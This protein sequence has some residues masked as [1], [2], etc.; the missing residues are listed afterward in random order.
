MH[1]AGFSSDTYDRYVLGLLE[2]PDRS[3][4]ESQIQEQC[5]A[6]LNGVQRSMN[7]WLVFAETLENAEPSEDFRG[8]VVRIAELSK[9]V[10]TFP[11]NSPALTERSGVP[12][13]TIVVIC[14]ITSVLIVATWYAARASV[15]LE[16]PTPSADLDTLADSLSKSKSLLDSEV[17]KRR[18]LENQMGTSGQQAIARAKTLEDLLAKAQDER[19]RAQAEVE[20]FKIAKVRDQQQAADTNTLLN[21]FAR[22]GARLIPMKSTEQAGKALGYAILAEHSRLVFVGTNLPTLPHELRFQLWIIRKDTPAEVS[23]G[24]FQA[25]EKGAT[26]VQYEEASL[27]TNVTGIL[28]TSEPVEGKYEKPTGPKMFEAS[29]VEAN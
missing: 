7:L 27:L 4:L 15:R 19:S 12:I 25:A 3:T 23:A 24:V 14:A 18:Q 9:K 11:K 21:A 22:T 5:P 20:Q 1:C 26:V 13:S 8:R 17:E 29:T 28:V 10:L 16:M 6:C 2:E